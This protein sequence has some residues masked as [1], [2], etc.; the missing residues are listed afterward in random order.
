MCRRAVIRA[1]VLRAGRLMRAGRGVRPG[2]EF[3]CGSRSSTCGRRSR[4]LSAIS[5]R[6]S[7][8]PCGSRG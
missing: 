2:P 8:W 4:C 7:A 5:S 6:G 1:G 3:P